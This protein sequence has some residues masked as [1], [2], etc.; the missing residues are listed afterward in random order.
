MRYAPFHRQ[1]GFASLI[2]YGV[3]AL[4]IIAGLATI[5]YSIRKAGYDAA[6]LECAQAA[7][8]Q[9]AREA[10]RA[11][12]AAEEL[13]NAKQKR[14]IVYRRIVREVDRIVVRYADKPCLDPD[15]VRIVNDA[16]RG[17]SAPAPEPASPLP[18]P[19]RTGGRVGGDDV[20]LGNENG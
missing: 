19:G 4:G 20:A 3:L 16:I 8:A 17:E 1:R 12:R 2:I 10:E 18:A 11:A 14:E 15:G 13:E 7:A 5:G 6:H 9:R